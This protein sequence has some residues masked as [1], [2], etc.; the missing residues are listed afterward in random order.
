MEDKPAKLG[1]SFI[2]VNPNCGNCEIRYTVI[3]IYME[4]RETAHYDQQRTHKYGIISYW[5]SLKSN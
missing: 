1:I 2:A 5:Y 3:E 4:F